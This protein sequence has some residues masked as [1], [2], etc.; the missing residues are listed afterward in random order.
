MILFIVEL[1]VFLDPDS[2]KQEDAE[3]LMNWLKTTLL[4][5]VNKVK[6]T[7]SPKLTYS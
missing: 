4:N 6:V 7:H 3:V 1:D 5:K 2:I